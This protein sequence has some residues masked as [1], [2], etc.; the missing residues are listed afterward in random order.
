MQKKLLIVFLVIMTVI[1]ININLVFAANVDV[2]L[3]RLDSTGALIKVKSDDKIVKVVMYRQDSTGEFVRF[4]ENSEDGYNEKN[5]FISPYR[6]SESNKTNLKVEVTNEKGEVKTD[7]LEIGSIPASPSPSTSPSPSVTPTTTPSTSPSTTPSTSPTTSVTPSPST[8][9]TPSPSNGNV[10]PTSVS[11][12]EKNLTLTIGQKKSSKLNLTIKPTNAQTKL[13]WS[14]SNKNVATVD[15][16][17]VVTGKKTGTATI[18]VKTD[19]GLVAECKVT[20]KVKKI[21]GTI[22]KSNSSFFSKI[23]TVNG[24]TAIQSLAITDKYYVCT[25]I[26]GDNSKATISVFDKKNK[27]RVNTLVGSF[28]HANGATYNPDTKSVYITHMGARNVSRI[29]ASNLT[30]SNLKRSIMKFPIT[31]TGLGYDKDSQKWVLKCGKNVSIYNKDLTK[32]LKSFQVAWHIGQDCEVYKGLLLSIDYIGHANAYIYVY[33]I[34]TGECYGRY[35]VTIPVE[36][37]SLA[38]DENSDSFVMVFN[39]YNGDKIYRTK[40]INLKNYY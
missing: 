25:K 7:T 24:C 19:N 36:L 16:K 40:A 39:D 9:T 21:S 28:G 18:K 38:Y 3:V 30:A 17:G 2:S 37:E 26:R 6:L 32:K 35:K 8:S 4:F 33:N 13:T 5:F 29:S 31:A 23:N 27:K 12:S 22:S 10:K 14:T 15:G 20:V 11:L 1:T 34:E